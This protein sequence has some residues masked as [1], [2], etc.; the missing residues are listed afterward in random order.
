MPRCCYVDSIEQ[1]DMGRFLLRLEVFK[2]DVETNGNV[3][4]QLSYP[5]GFILRPDMTKKGSIRAACSGRD[6]SLSCKSDSGIQKFV[7]Y[8]VIVKEEGGPEENTT[9]PTIESFTLLGESCEAR[10][11]CPPLG[12]SAEK[13]SGESWF[14]QTTPL[15]AFGNV[16]NY[17]ILVAALVGVAA[18]L[19]LVYE[20]LQLSYFRRFSW[21]RRIRRDRNIRNTG[22][23]N[24]SFV[25]QSVGSNSLPTGKKLKRATPNDYAANDSQTYAYDHE[26]LTGRQQWPSTD[27]PFSQDSGSERQTIRFSDQQRPSRKQSKKNKR[28]NSKSKSDSNSTVLAYPKNDKDKETRQEYDLISLYS[29]T[30]DERIAHRDSHVSDYWQQAPPLP[31]VPRP[32]LDRATRSNA[33]RPGTPVY[34]DLTIISPRRRSPTK[35]TS[36][37]FS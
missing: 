4:W 35:S 22:G 33:K 30:S 11:S 10:I 15:G 32:F 37:E 18:T 1:V 16:T 6:R 7:T 5:E 17:I 21:L 36:S 27:A 24:M 9:R 13:E 12:I 19:L 3:E 14:L 8:Y 26:G 28:S 23:E 29:D 25:H 2:Y 34:D 31:T 20:S